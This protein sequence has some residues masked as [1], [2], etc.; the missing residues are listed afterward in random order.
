[1][2]QPNEINYG[3]YGLARARDGSDDIYLF[4]AP[5]AADS[6]MKVAKVTEA[7]IADKTKYTYWDGSK[8][9]PTPPSAS[10]TKSD[11]FSNQGGI[12]TGVSLCRST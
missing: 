7:S 8:W 11:I 5:S 3:L 9:A 12:G 1:M 2:W 4:V 10:D 6:G